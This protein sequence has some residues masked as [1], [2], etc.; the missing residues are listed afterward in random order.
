MAKDEEVEWRRMR[1]LN[2]E[3]SIILILPR[4]TGVK[5]YKIYLIV[6]IFKYY[7]IVTSTVL[8][9]RGIIYFFRN[10]NRR[11]IKAMIIDERFFISGSSIDTISV[12]R[13]VST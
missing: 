6:F 4:E 2:G 11:K 9:Y 3:G 7:I 13:I 5:L 12:I 1:R 8:K 10:Y